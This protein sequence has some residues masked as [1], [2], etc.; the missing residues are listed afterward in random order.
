M[1]HHSK[2]PNRLHSPGPTGQDLREVLDEMRDHLA[3]EERLQAVERARQTIEAATEVELFASHLEYGST[4]AAGRA[5][6][7]RGLRGEWALFMPGADSPRPAQPPEREVAVRV[8]RSL[9]Y[10]MS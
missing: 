1:L 4:G 7:R 6:A 8:R 9:G 5:M 3:G 10:E 2:D